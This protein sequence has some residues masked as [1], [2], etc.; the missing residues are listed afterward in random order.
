MYGNIG[1][2]TAPGTPGDSDPSHYVNGNVP[3]PPPAGVI[4]GRKYRDVSGNG[5]NTVA[6]PNSPAD[7]PLA[8]VTVYLDLN[9]DGVKQ[10]GEPSRVTDA[11]GN[12]SFTGLALD[13]TYNVREVVPEGWLRTFPT[14]SNV[15]TATLTA[16]SP[17][18]TNNDFANFETVCGP[19]TFSNVSFKIVHADG[20]SEVVSDL[21]GQTMEGDRITVTFWVDDAGSFTASF[22][23]YTAPEPYFDADTASQQEIYEVVSG[24][25]AQGGPYTLTISVPNSY[26]QVDFVCGPVIDRLGPAGSN[27]FYT[28]QHRLV[29]ADNGGTHA[30]VANAGSV[31]GVKY[32]DL[33]GDGVRDSGEP[34][35]KDWVIYVD[36]DNDGVRDAGEYATVTRADGSYTISNLPTG[37]LLRVKEVQQTGWVATQDCRRPFTLGAGEDK[38]AG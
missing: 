28:P 19:C 25:F 27:I 23:S 18:D 24:T 7:T 2:V 30:P 17:V 35:L 5:L 34:G 1:Y 38:T 10:S 11:D 12:Y 15:H 37:T 3:P 16:A 22:V 32:K 20:T 33:D 6:G 14:L 21:R 29:S 36:A 26:Y 9:N 13:A 4:T 31:S 8:G